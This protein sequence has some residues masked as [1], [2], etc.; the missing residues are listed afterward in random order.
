MP[1]QKQLK[2]SQLKVGLTVVLASITLAVL[3][4]LMSGT[5]GLFTKKIEIKSYFDNAGGLRVG[6]PVRLNG[7]DVGNV[8]EHPRGRRCRQEAHPGGSRDESEH[9]VPVW[10]SHGFPD[11][12]RHRW[13]PRRNL[14]RYRQFAGK[15]PVGE[16]RGYPAHQG[17]SRHSGRRSRQPGHLAEPRCTLEATDRIIAFIESGQGSVGKLIYDPTLYNRLSSTVN[18]FQGLVNQVNQGN[19]TIGKLIFDDELYRKANTTVDKLN[20][21]IDDLNA[22]RE[23]PV[24]YSKIR[25]STTRPTRPSRM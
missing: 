15:R 11:H 6:A 16:E 13:G 25:A 3:I 1:S 24:N 10:A 7:V 19:G 23:R 17:S 9:Q 8:T 2:W 18:E 14:H 20:V 22:G 12:P 4:F 5:G 21:V